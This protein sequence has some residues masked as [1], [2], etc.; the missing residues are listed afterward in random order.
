MHIKAFLHETLIAFQ[1]LFVFSTAPRLKHDTR[2]ASQ[3]D[4]CTLVTTNFNKRNLK[5]YIN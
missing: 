2:R 3:V 4:D 1:N 5:N